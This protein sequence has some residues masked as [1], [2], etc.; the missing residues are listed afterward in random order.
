MSLYLA[1]YEVAQERSKHSANQSWC[2]A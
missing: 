1:M 2:S